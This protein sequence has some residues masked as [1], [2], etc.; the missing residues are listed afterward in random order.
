MLKELWADAKASMTLVAVVIGA[1]FASG[2]EVLRFFTAFGEWSWACCFV[3]AALLSGLFAWA[4]ILSGKLS[5]YDLTALSQKALGGPGGKIAAFLNGVLCVATAGAMLSAMGEV[6]ALALPIRPAYWIGVFASL[7]IA[8]FIAHKGLE[9]LAMVGG[10]LVLLCLLLYSLLFRL[11]PPETAALPY[12]GN[13]FRAVPLAATYAAMNAALGCGTLCE[14]GRGK[15]KRTIIRICVLTGIPLLLLLLFANAVLY[16]HRDALLSEALP[17]VQLARSLGPL[18]YGMCLITLA[19]S[20]TTTLVALLRT[21]QRM[22]RRATSEHISFILALALP[23]AT[24][25]TG[26]TALVKYVYPLLGVVCTLLFLAMI[27]K[28]GGVTDVTE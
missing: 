6:A 1:G 2:R 10:C 11:P 19:L 3:A 17:V 5:A 8:G 18:G 12:A 15:R 22:M 26:F 7:I 25:S 28:G 14:L 20:I 24:A 21:L 4:A 16:P 13:G 27:V 9:L 23:L